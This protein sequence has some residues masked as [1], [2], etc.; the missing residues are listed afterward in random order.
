MR[1]ASVDDVDAIAALLRAGFAG[2][3]ELYTP[4][5]FAATTPPAATLAGRLEE[6]PTWVATIGDEVAGTVSAWANAVKCHVRSMAVHPAQRGRGVARMLLDAAE[7]WAVAGR[8]PRMTLETTSFLTDAIRLYTASGFTFT[9]VE[10]DL[11]GTRVF[12]MEK[13][14]AAR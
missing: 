3:E 4:D 8:C 7:Q 14:L 11:C 2:F 6:G 9:G 12:E 13:R 1:R 10:R 5:A